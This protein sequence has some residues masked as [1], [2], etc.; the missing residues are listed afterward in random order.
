MSRQAGTLEEGIEIT[1][2]MIAAGVNVVAD[3]FGVLGHYAAEDLSD[4][5]FRA[6]ATVAGIV[7]IEPDGKAPRFG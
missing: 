2:A 6:M 7:I 1:P 3:E 5:V 4:C